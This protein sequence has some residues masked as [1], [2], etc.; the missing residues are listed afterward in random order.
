[1][2]DK[3]TISVSQNI[4][5]KKNI[6][7]NENTTEI[8]NWETPD[9]T[10]LKDPKWNFWQ[11]LYLIL[12]ILL[13]ETALGWLKQPDSLGSLKGFM[14]FTGVGIGEAL[15]YFFAVIVFLKIWRRPLSDLGLAKSVGKSWIFGVTGGI[16]LFFLVG[17]LGNLI[18]S[19]VDSPVPQSFSMAVAGSN[20]IWQLIVLLLLGGII[21][22]LKEELVYRGLVYPPLRRDYGK[23]NGIV[24]SALFFGALHFDMLRFF[25]LF[26]GGLI[27]A[28]LYEK[29][30]N[31]WTPVIAHGVW[32]ILMT[33]LMWWQ[34]G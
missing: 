17:A 18:I 2:T 10:A 5:D 11:A 21:V 6:G 9:T 16:I 29:T 26:I 20:S 8:K 31:L 30:Q 34:K 4:T 33:V 24:L 3:R 28:W 27:L 13:L 15:L 23:L 32:N 14:T 22:P 25:P 7:D 1:M 12:L 19:F